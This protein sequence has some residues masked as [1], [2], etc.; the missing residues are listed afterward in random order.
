M[1]SAF[2]P[3]SPRRSMDPGG[4]VLVSNGSPSRSG[5]S[6]LGFECI[7]FSAFCLL[8]FAVPLEWG[9]AL[10][11]VARFNLGWE[12]EKRAHAIRCALGASG[13]RSYFGFLFRVSR[14]NWL[15]FRLE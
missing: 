3:G 13:F 10:L 7:D 5:A 14:G 11:L 8:G 4:S 1:V 6:T 9:H 2:L 15:V 12:P